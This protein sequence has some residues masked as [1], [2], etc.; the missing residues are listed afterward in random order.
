MRSRTY[1]KTQLAKVSPTGLSN[2]VSF[3]LRSPD[4]IKTCSQPPAS[5]R[6]HLPRRSRRC[7]VLF[8]PFVSWRKVSVILCYGHLVGGFPSKYLPDE[9]LVLTAFSFSTTAVGET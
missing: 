8:V 4:S 6:L 7:S 3:R 1:Q 9:K 2:S 5:R